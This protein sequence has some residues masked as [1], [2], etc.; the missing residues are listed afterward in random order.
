MLYYIIY[1]H[2]YICIYIYICIFSHFTPQYLWCNVIFPGDVLAIPRTEVCHRAAE[3]QQGTAGF[4]GRGPVTTRTVNGVDF[5]GENG[6]D[7]QINHHV[8]C[9][10]YLKH[11]FLLVQP[12]VADPIDHVCCLNFETTSLSDQPRILLSSP[13]KFGSTH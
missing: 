11:L 7:N 8:C 2:T 5:M 12:T 4:R 3:L 10:L 1:I 6:L 13:S 9:C